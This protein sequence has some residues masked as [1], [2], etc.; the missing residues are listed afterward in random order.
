MKENNESQN[1]IKDFPNQETKYQQVLEE[2]KQLVP[3]IEEEMKKCPSDELTF[4]LYETVDFYSLKRNFKFKSKSSDNNSI[5]NFKEKFL[6]GLSM[7]D[8]FLVIPVN[9]S[10]TLDSSSNKGNK[11]RSPKVYDINGDDGYLSQ[12]S[13]E[14]YLFLY[15]NIDDLD[16]FIQK[17][18]NNNLTCFCLGVNMNFL[19]T[20][21]WIKNNKLLNKNNFYFYFVSSG[22][23]SSIVS[24]NTT[25]LKYYNLPRIVVIG[26]DNIIHEDKYIRNIQSF[27]INRDL[28]NNTNKNNKSEDGQQSNFVILENDNKRKIIKAINVYIKS[29]GL[30]DVHFYVK[31]KVSIDKNGI[32]KIKCYPAF[33]GETTRSGKKMVD[34][35]VKT[36][37]EQEL[38]KDVQNKVIFK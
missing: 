33:Y 13:N 21:K 1:E 6:T 11:F 17:N 27:D 29:A 25:N 23:N 12:G 15:D 36:L 20:K 2:M 14:I 22:L 7:F 38:F 10:Y 28:M 31:S 24:E 8:T 35:L 37:N 4:T 5:N 3:F 26:S 19:E 16:F 9:D 18:Y 34:Y 32:K 30:K